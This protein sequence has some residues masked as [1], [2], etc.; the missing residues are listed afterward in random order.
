MG[1]FLRAVL[2]HDLMGAV[3]HGDEVNRAALLDWA[4]HLHNEVPGPCHGSR[5]ALTAWYARGGE[6][7]VE[8]E[9]R[10]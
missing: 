6:L 4:T 7:G 5:E 9:E 10:A 8:R 2:L 3:R 1:S